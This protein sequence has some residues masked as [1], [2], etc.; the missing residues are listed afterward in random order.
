MFGYFQLFIETGTPLDNLLKPPNQKQESNKLANQK[1][2]GLAQGD[3]EAMLKKANN[4]V[5]N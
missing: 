1:Q 2:D 5:E 4:K 3:F